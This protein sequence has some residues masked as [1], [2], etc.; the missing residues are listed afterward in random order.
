MTNAE[1]N[2]I[3]AQIEGAMA[4]VDRICRRVN[5]KLPPAQE[6]L[7]KAREHMVLA[8]EHVQAGRAE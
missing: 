8:K 3:I 5:G 7:K 1:K 2:R 4:D 6:Q